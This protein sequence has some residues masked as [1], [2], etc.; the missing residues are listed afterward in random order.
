MPHPI[1][2]V[3]PAD[4]I[5]PVLC[6]G[7]SAAVTMARQSIVKLDAREPFARSKAERVLFDALA[8]DR[9]TTGAFALNAK[10][11]DDEIDLLAREPRIAVEVDGWYWHMRSPD[12]YRRDRAKDLAMQRAGYLVMRVLAEDVDDRLA[13]LVDE[14]AIVLAARRRAP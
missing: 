10:L 5:D 1:G 13:Y 8:A 14:I 4:V 7:R 3:A 6:D 11:D 2:I 9:R 12:T